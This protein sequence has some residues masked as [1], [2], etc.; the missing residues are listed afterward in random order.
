MRRKELAQKLVLG[1]L[2]RTQFVDSMTGRS[3]ASIDPARLSFQPDK[4][5]QRTKQGNNA[6]VRLMNPDNDRL[7]RVMNGVIMRPRLF[8]YFV[9]A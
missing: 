9:W 4:A 8:A 3:T 5:G 6:R 1:F 2:I 7:R